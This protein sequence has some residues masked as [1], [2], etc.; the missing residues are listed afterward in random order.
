MQSHANFSSSRFSTKLC[1]AEE[2]RLPA[3]AYA[4]LRGDVQGVCGL[5]VDA[6]PRREG[7]VDRAAGAHPG[8][9]G[10]SDGGEAAAAGGDVHVRPVRQR[11][12]P[13]DRLDGLHAAHH[14]PGRRLQGQ[15]ERRQAPPPDQGIQVR[16]VPGKTDAVVTFTKL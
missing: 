9:R 10:A 7:V 8:D 16:Q 4:A 15:Q 14:V 6:D 12:V 3:G 13:A 1:P 11:D 2:E 5:Q